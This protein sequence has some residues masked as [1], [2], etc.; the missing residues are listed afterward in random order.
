MFCTY[1]YGIY[2]HRCVYLFYAKQRSRAA[3]HTHT[4]TPFCPIYE[5]TRPIHEKQ[6]PTYEKKRPIHEKGGPIYEQ[7]GPIYEEKRPIYGKKEEDDLDVRVCI[8]VP[9]VY[10]NCIM[11]TC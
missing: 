7:K 5:K 10:M 3:L 6:R 8:S 2:T 9:R 1:I 4:H 11:M